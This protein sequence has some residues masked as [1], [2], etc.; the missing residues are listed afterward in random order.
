M[1]LLGN[2]STQ[3]V[4][5]ENCDQEPIHIPGRIQSH[6]VLF[7]LDETTLTIRQISA[8][9]PSVLSL[10]PGDL[11]D[12][13]V[14]SLFDSSALTYFLNCIHKEDL[15]AN[16]IYLATLRTNNDHV[17][18]GIVHRYD[19]LLVVELEPS[20]ASS[21][22]RGVVDPV[23]SLRTSLISLQ[24]T[25]TLQELARLIT[26]QVR[27]LTG[28]DRVMIYKFQADESGA[29]IAEDA[30]PELPSYLGLH[31]P[32]SDIP[33][34]ARILYLRNWL[35]LIVNLAD[36]PAPLTPEI[37]PLTQRPLDMSYATLRSVSPI[38]IEYLRNMGATASMSISLIKE[39]TLWGLIACHHYSG[40]KYIPY[41]LRVA[42]E[43]LGQMV[44]MQLKTKEEQQDIVY[45]QTLQQRSSRFLE[46]MAQED[47]FIDGLTQHAP[48]LLQF[49]D[50]EGA[51]VAAEGELRLLGKTPS[52]HEVRE[53]IEWLAA[54]TT[55]D[56]FVTHTLPS[57]YGKAVAYKDIACGLMAASISR[58]QKEYLLWFR[59]EVLQV[60]HWAGDPTKSIERTGDGVRL[61]PRKSFAAWQETVRLQSLPWKKYEQAAAAALRTAIRDVI[62]HSARQLATTHAELVR[63][64]EEL[65]AFV[66]AISH[67]LREPL[68]GIHHYAEFLLE[69]Q[70]PQLN[71]EGQERL[72]TMSHLTERMESMLSSLLQ[73]SRFGKNA[74]RFQTISLDDV[75]RDALAILHAS[76]EDRH[77]QIRTPHPLPLVRCDPTQ[78]LEVLVNLLS[79]AIKYN[80][81][82]EGWIEVGYIDHQGNEPEQNDSLSFVFYV[83]DNGIGIREQHYDE[84]FHL[85]RRL[86][87][88][89]AFG[90]GNGAGLTI[91][92]KILER[93]GGR[94]WVESALGV[95]STF[96]FTLKGDTAD[97]P[98]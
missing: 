39:G 35:R 12:E 68:R 80:D 46:Y 53:L 64:N 2:P 5:L 40:A 73:Y 94:I 42:C 70:A 48:N 47:R 67:D 44:S 72:R 25:A 96:Y 95:G 58:S 10:E 71:T 97:G 62:L 43:L 88:R 36:E 4:D 82:E 81:K 54:S 18:D 59:P 69:D 17:F 27:A 32:A 63:K 31:Y 76:L 11:L 37:N 45:A 66:Y 74:L 78:M 49:L 56:V 7:V 79:N 28:F 3:T 6:G 92:K 61:S 98:R 23:S 65:D 20:L 90:G 13:P 85:F 83:R 16:P 29:V 38:H 19:G 22:T 87:S 84:I 26:R 60:V 30:A 33:R 91:V 93:H 15:E 41:D 52:E 34:Q 55:E 77:I 21:S 8:N 50:A 57:F 1:S 24:R 89:D 86:H 51:A 9:T 14:S 75:V